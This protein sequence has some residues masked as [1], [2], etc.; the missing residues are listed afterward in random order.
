M[1]DNLRIKREEMIKSEREEF[2]RAKNE[3]RKE[4]ME[5]YEKKKQ[6]IHDLQREEAFQSLMALSSPSGSSVSSEGF[7]TPTKLL[8]PMTGFMGTPALLPKD[9]TS[10][11]KKVFDFPSYLS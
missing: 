1:A 10:E 6:R 4:M 3:R 9:Y 7:F 11:K 8:S 2:E 5:E